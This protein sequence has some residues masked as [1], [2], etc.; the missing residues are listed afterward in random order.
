V[1][2][3][4]ISSIPYVAPELS[5]IILTSAYFLG[6]EGLDRIPKITANTDGRGG[7][8]GGSSGGVECI[9]NRKLLWS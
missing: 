6:F 1:L 9:L 5:F 3:F 8:G 2:S 7:K 4:I